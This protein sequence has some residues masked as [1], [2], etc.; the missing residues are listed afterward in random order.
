MELLQLQYFQAIATYGSMRTAA[1][2]LFVS[3][4]NLSVSMTRLEESLGF[5][6]FVRQKGKLTL[7]K[8]W[9][10]FLD[11]V[12]RINSDLERTVTEIRSSITKKE[13]SV[14]VATSINDLLG[15]ILESHYDEL[16][17]LNIYQQYS[18][19]EN[20]SKLILEHRADWGIVYGINHAIHLHHMMIPWKP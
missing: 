17:H 20:I 9:L 1:Q 8:E 7:T 6:L 2:M 18:D 12:N 15:K 5:S 11:C 19:N 16:A 13:E 4:P 14:R 3:Q 10:Q